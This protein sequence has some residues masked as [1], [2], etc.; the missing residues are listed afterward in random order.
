[1]EVGI[2]LLKSVA[3]LSLFYGVYLLFLRKETLFHTKRHFFLAGII[4]AL[5]VPFIQFTNTVIIEVPATEL[6]ALIPQTQNTLA[7][8]IPTETTATIDYGFWA[9]LLY[10]LGALIMAFKF[11]RELFSLLYLIKG[12]PASSIGKYTFVQVDDMI[13]PFS[14][15]RFIVYN[16]KLHT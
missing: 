14:F 5:V 3:V 13:A 7:N 16:P 2:Y 15:F 10:T 6:T 1:M 8:S 9:M 11:S 12:R 4:A